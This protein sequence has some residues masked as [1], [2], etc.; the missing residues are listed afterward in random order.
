[1]HLSGAPHTRRTIPFSFPSGRGD[2]L[3]GLIDVPAGA[4]LSYGVF[5]PCFTCVKESHAAVKI[6]RALAEKGVAML[7]FDT[8]G[9]GGSK[10]DIRETNFTTRIQDLRAACGALAAKHGTPRLLAGHSLSGTAALSAAKHLP[11]IGVVATIG[12][13]ADPAKVIEKFRSNDAIAV[14]GDLAEID[15][16]GYVH[17]F[18]K[19]FIDD[20][21][22]QHVAEDTAA[23][24]KKLFIFHAPKDDIV[25]YANA[26]VIAE[27][28]GKN[29]ELVTLDAGATHLFN[30]RATDAAFVAET[31]AAWMKA[32]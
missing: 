12:S 20:M 16:L 32:N 5:G 26:G 9:V 2:M 4:P 17:T 3:S 22:A 18:K 31:L 25:A 7:R 1:M 23:L 28:A 15:V 19:T 24:G 29:A 14:R 13:P 10:G 6:C 30:N 11:E 8:T 27:R 21:L